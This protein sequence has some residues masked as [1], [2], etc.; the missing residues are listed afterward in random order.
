MS[1]GPLPL[2]QC[3]ACGDCL[4]LDLN[5]IPNSGNALWCKN[6]VAIKEQVEIAGVGNF[7]IEQKLPFELFIVRKPG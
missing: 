3:A 6:E 7:H 5:T 1:L 4:I 2:N